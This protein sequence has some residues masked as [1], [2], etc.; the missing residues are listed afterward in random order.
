MKTSKK[1]QDVLERMAASKRPFRLTPILISA[2]VSRGIGGVLK[3]WRL[4]ENSG[5][6]GL[7]KWIGGK[8]PANL[9]D[10]IRKELIL[11]THGHKPINKQHNSEKNGRKKHT[12]K[13]QDGVINA[14]GKTSDIDQAIALL[15]SFGYA[16]MRPTFVEV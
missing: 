15:K 7:W 16:V 12:R 1:Y 13:S 4:I 14:L 6:N 3:E 11:R 5:V 10:K 9:G 8:V 2:K